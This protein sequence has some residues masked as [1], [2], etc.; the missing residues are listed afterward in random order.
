MLLNTAA[1]QPFP[2]PVHPVPGERI[3]GVSSD[4]P[5]IIRDE[6]PDEIRKHRHLLICH[7]AFS[8]D[9]SIPSPSV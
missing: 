3:S 1:D 6:L 5:V 2:L 7:N 9:V 8:H 4:R